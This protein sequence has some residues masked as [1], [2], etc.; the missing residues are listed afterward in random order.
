MRA[1]AIKEVFSQE[2]MPVPS[3]LERRLDDEEYDLFESWCCGLM[4]GA[5]PDGILVQAYCHR[6]RGV[7]KPQW[8]VGRDGSVAEL[9][10]Q[11]P[12]WLYEGGQ[13]DDDPEDDYFFEDRDEEDDPP[14][15]LF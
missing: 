4:A 13:D 9:S 3:F 5:G 12:D 6:G 11:S 15:Q 14:W 1:Q 7:G 8:F 10:E 2:G